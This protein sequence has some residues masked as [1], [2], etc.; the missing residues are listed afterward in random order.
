MRTVTDPRRSAAGFTLVELLVVI[1]I[2][3]TLV[4]LLLPAVQVARESARRSSCTNKLKQMALAVHSHEV[5]RRI[6]PPLS[7]NPLL[8]N[9]TQF[10]GQVG[11]WGYRVGFIPPLFPFMDEQGLYDNVVN[12]MKD[13]KAPWETGDGFW[14]SP[15]TTTSNNKQPSVLC[16]PSDSRAVRGAGI[17]QNLGVTSYRCNRGDIWMGDGTWE[18]R[19]PFGMGNRGKCNLAR[20][21]DGS[22]KT[23]MLSEATIGSGNRSPKSGL[24][25]AGG[26]SSTASPSVCLGRLG[27]GGLVGNVRTI[28]DAGKDPSLGFRWCDSRHGYIA[29]YTVLPPNSPSCSNGDA[30]NVAVVSPNSYHND[31]ANVAMCDASVRY[32]S[33][34][35]DAGDPTRSMPGNQYT[36]PS[37]WG[38][39]GALGTTSGGEQS[40]HLD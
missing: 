19:G 13:G 29:F 31:G 35:I 38:V 32:V 22:S 39:W 23:V 4:G 15:K 26:I 20:I 5:A 16:C 36:G 10:N 14:A 6:F 1:A 3:G 30:E 7:D 12:Y 18:W 17:G 40:V 25:T 27:A 24:S 34:S 9:M 2:I 8:S 37:L 21:P 33:N 11:G 28:A